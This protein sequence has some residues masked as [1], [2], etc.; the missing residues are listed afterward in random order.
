MRRP[1]TI[2]LLERHPLAEDADLAGFL[3]RQVVMEATRI[4]QGGRLPN[5]HL[6]SVRVSLTRLSIEVDVEGEDE[7]QL[8]AAVTAADLVW[9][10][11]A[12]RAFRAAT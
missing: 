2:V 11:V 3:V 1:A 12:E 8:D 6:V 10:A 9:R 7:R 5:V 4:A